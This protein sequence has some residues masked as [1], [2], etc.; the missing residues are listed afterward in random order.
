MTR[1]E[2]LK[3]IDE[4]YELDC[5]GVINLVEGLGLSYLSFDML[6]GLFLLEGNKTTIHVEAKR[7]FTN[8]GIDYPSEQEWRKT[9]VGY[10]YSVDLDWEG[11][12]R[13]VKCIDDDKHKEQVR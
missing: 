9:F 7:D 11:A 2:L 13:W 1:E 4:V 12:N 5:F 3:K 10:D 8:Y 6:Y